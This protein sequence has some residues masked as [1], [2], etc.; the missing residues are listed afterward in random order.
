MSEEENFVR[1]VHER[2]KHGRD[3]DI[4]RVMFLTT[5]HFVRSRAERSRT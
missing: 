5:T 4:V 3:S 2:P 1:E